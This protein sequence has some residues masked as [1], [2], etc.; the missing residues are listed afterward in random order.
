MAVW[1][2]KE[3]A[4]LMERFKLCENRD[5]QK[6]KSAHYKIQLAVPPWLKTVM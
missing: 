3:L 4:S 6:E 2:F 1:V 5:F